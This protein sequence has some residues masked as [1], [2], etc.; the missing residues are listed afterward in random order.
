MIGHAIG[1][2]HEHTRPDRDQ[3]V[4]ILSSNIKPEELV[5]FEIQDEFRVNMS[6]VQYDFGSIMHY[7]ANVSRF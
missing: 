7:S 5:N 3:Y 1:F 2:H 6:D 4:R